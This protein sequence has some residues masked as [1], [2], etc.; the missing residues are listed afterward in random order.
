[1]D[2]LHSAYDEEFLFMQL[3]PKMEGLGPTDYPPVPI[4]DGI[5]WRPIPELHMFSQ[6]GPRSCGIS[7]PRKNIDKWH[8]LMSYEAKLCIF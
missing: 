7:F 8:L 6:S 1:M 3:S 4:T 5:S 2:I